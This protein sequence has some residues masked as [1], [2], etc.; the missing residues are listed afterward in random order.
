[1]V[2]LFVLRLR[3]AIALFFLGGRGLVSPAGMKIGVA[4]YTRYC[5][6]EGKGEKIDDEYV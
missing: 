6:D 2:A 5:A 3:A 1:V 4:V